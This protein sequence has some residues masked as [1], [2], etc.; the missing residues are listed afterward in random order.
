M[1]SNQDALKRYRVIHSM[2]RRGGRVKTFDIVRECNNRGVSVR[3]R[4]IQKDIEDL[5]EDPQLGFF[6]PIE[7]DTISKAYYYSEIPK[8]IFPSLELEEDEINALLFYAK[9]INQYQE[10]PIFQEISNAVSKVIENSNINPKTKELFEKETLL[11]TEKHLP[12]HGLE[13]ITDILFAIAQK[14]AIEFG[15]QKF[16]ESQSQIRKIKPVLLKE[17]KKM[18]YVLGEDF[19]HQRITTFALD[20][21]NCLK[22]TDEE[23]NPVTFNSKEYFKYSFGITVSNEAPVD[24]IISFNPLTGNYLKTLP[25]HPSQQII[26]DSSQT[27][28]IKITVIPSYEFYSKILSYGSDAVILEPLHLRKHFL[29]CFEG[30]VTKYKS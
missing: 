14:R 17:D 23:F 27:F 13:M 16:N 30:A 10:Y 8:N 29:N 20:R 9:V 21:I 5:V 19:K 28:T 24:V 26:E 3:T 1:P 6:L 18:W 15:Y 2:L 25:I 4:T 7:K 12:I 11:E 22:I